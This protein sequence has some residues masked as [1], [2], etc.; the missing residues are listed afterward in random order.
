M[1]DIGR[2]LLWSLRTTSTRSRRSKLE[3]SI[4]L[5]PISQ[6]R[7]RQALQRAQRLIRNPQQAAESVAQLQQ[8]LPDTTNRPRVRKIIGKLGQEFFLLSPH[9]VLAFQA[10]GEIVWI[11]TAKQRYIATQNLRSIEERLANS[12]FRRVHRNALVNVEQIR[13]MSMITSQRWLITLSNGQEFIVSKRQAK[14][15][16]D[17]LNW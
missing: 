14:N 4:I 16:R 1:A 5:K 15:V 3:R 17:V 10:E 6:P 13:K 2:Q 9:E 11:I 8:L 12:S 7:L